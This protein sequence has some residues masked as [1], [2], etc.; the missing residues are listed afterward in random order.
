MRLVFCG[1]A[2]E[3]GASCLFLEIGGK[4]L[5]LD[6]GMRMTKTKDNLPD[7]R[8]IQENGG[9][10]GIFISH[11][12]MDHIGALPI[13]SREYPEALIYCTLA[14]KDLI[15]LLLFD[16]LKIMEKQEAEIPIFSEVHVKSMLD[17]II[18]YNPNNVIHVFDQIKASF[19]NAGHILGASSIYLTSDEGSFFYSGD[20]SVTPQLTVEG[21][22]I[23]KLRPDVAVFESTY[24]DRLHSNRQGEEKR[25]VETVKKVIEGKGKILIPAFALGRAQEVILILK[26]AIGKKELSDIPVYIDGMVKD[27]CTIYE[28]HPNY[29][30][31]A[32]MRKLLKGNHIFTDD[33]VVK[34]TDRAMR[35]QIMES[36]DPCCII[37]SSGMLTGG[38]SQEYAKAFFSQENHYI[39][40]TGYQDEEAPGRNLLSLAEDES[41]E[42]EKL[43]FLDGVNYSVKCGVGKYG[44]SAHGDKS[45]ITSLVTNMAPR[46]IFFNH[47]DSKVISCLASDIAKE[48]Y[49]QIEVPIN[50]EPYE[51]DI[52]NPRKQIQRTKPPS[53]GRYEELTE[54]NITDLREYILNKLDAKKGYT[55]EE[56]FELW[57]GK[58]PVQEQLIALNRLLNQSPL[59]KHDYKRTYIFHPAEE[60]EIVNKSVMDIHEMMLFA[61]E[62]FPKESG[63]YKKGARFDEKIAILNFDYPLMAKSKYGELIDEFQHKTGWKVE[64]NERCNFNAACLLISELLEQQQLCAGKISYYQDIGTFVVKID[65]TLQDQS[66]IDRFHELTGMILSIEKEKSK[67]VSINLSD[68]TYSQP[69]EQNEAFKIIDRYVKEKFDHMIYRKSIKKVQNEPYIELSFITRQIGEQYINEIKELSQIIGWPLTINP[70]TN[71]FELNTMARKLLEQYNVQ[72]YGKISYIPGEEFMKVKNVEASDEVKKSIQA[73]FYKATGMDITL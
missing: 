6:C 37:S 23:P 65:K 4:K 18:C 70:M 61:D 26:R 1:G 44:L 11:A 56:L 7:F 2:E 32:H 41:N 45:Q 35:K 8:I 16:S 5:L 68:T 64:V 15:R 52:R 73:D 20:F 54:E 57:Y 38:P 10:D 55:V 14:T 40:I 30:R 39:A 43:L 46:R 69:M 3:V 13:I 42:K 67:F 21:A 9:I 27:V 12:H 63:L 22:A 66:I 36:S 29:L 50:S 48:M 28:N 49:A 31:S 47:G 24:G 51:L 33:N 71:N 53:L 72:S 59:F 25:L 58:E 19:F 17:R 34:V 60:Q 62:Y